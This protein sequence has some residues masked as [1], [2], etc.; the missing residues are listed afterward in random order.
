MVGRSMRLPNGFVGTLLLFVV[1][2][3]GGVE[4]QPLLPSGPEIL[5]SRDGVQGGGLAAVFPDGGFVVAWTACAPL[6]AGGQCGIRA[7]L[8]ASDGA[9][10]SSEISLLHPADQQLDDLA[11]TAD[12]GFWVVWEQQYRH[13]T[14]SVVQAQRYDHQ[15]RPLT[16]PLFVQDR[17]DRSS[18]YRYG[19]RLAVAADGG[20]VIAWVAL[21]RGADRLFRDDIV[22]HFFA[23]DGT[24]LAPARNLGSGD[25][26]ANFPDRVGVEP[27][28]S[29]WILKESFAGANSF[30]N[31]Y[32]QHLA[33]DGT[34]GPRVAIC[35]GSVVCMPGLTL[36]YV[37]Q[38]T[39]AMRPDGTFVVLWTYTFL[40]TS[41][42]VIL[43]RIFAADGAPLGDAFEVNR[44]LTSEVGPVVAALSDGR[45]VA[46][47]SDLDDAAN[48][49][50]VYG[51]S[52]AA[53][54]T[55]TSGDFR[56][57]EGV[58]G[59][60]AAGGGGNVVAIFQVPDGRLVAQRFTTP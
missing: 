56:P 38:G 35:T 1:A 21:D 49:A 11:P 15:A 53:D 42:S 12:G 40:D 36:P 20:A 27:D 60:L 50:G 24:P 43:G 22:V 16:A 47:W 58:P 2:G 37:S 57:R 13:N 46:L 45:F 30:G 33:A 32:L 3:A 4:A 23:P 39:L 6:S 7:R 55:P 28:G 41:E 51:R 31:L 25:Q 48:L 26:Y 18:L 52:F 17:G 14:R 10:R 54:G 59:S 5:V 29:A 9:P 44:F 19:A 34:A 8:F